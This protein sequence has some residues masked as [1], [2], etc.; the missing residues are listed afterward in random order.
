MS[1]AQNNPKATPAAT[2]SEGRSLAS[3][4]ASGSAKKWEERCKRAES[5]LREC[6]V[7][8]TMVP[9]TSKPDVWMGLFQ[10]EY[11]APLLR[12][13]RGLSSPNKAVRP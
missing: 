4:L 11:I 2:P 9:A 7:V 10:S 6:D 13:M 12:K 5:L 3:A 1:R 8:L